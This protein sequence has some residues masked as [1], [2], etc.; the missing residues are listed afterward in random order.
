MKNLSP[1]IFCNLRNTE[2]VLALRNRHVFTERWTL[3][4][5]YRE[6]V[7]SDSDLYVINSETL[8]FPLQKITFSDSRNGKFCFGL[9]ASSSRFGLTVRWL[10]CTIK[11]GAITQLL[12]IFT[13]FFLSPIFSI[14][15]LL[16]IRQDWVSVIQLARWP[17]DASTSA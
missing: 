9:L 3:S 10:K 1:M 14:P 17:D 7:C 15:C 5:F 12:Y 6:K 11:L 4:I 16:C 13:F 2:P 8:N